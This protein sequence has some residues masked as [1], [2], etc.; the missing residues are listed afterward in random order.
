MSRRAHDHAK[1]EPLNR[2]TFFISTRGKRKNKNEK[3]AVSS[4]IVCKRRSKRL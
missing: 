1:S 4:E 2:S 3:D